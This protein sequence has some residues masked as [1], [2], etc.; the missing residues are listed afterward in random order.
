M[1]GQMAL[2]CYQELPVWQADEIPDALRAGHAFN[3]GEWVCL[4]VL[5]GRLKYSEADS[6]T[7]TEL[8]DENGDQMIAPQQQFTVEPLTDDTEIKLSLYC[9]AKDYFNKK[10]GMSATHSAVVTT[11]NIANPP[12]GKPYVL[13]QTLVKT[14]KQMMHFASYLLQL[15]D[16]KRELRLRLPQKTTITQPQAVPPTVICSMRMV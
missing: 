1:D 7:N 13:G 12:H 6:V 14:A 11:E 3:E 5:Q 2:L 16:N 10:Y 15:N 8:T 4:N 9:A